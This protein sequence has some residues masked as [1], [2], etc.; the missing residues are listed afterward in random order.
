MR[1][2]ERPEGEGIIYGLF[3]EVGKVRIP[4]VFVDRGLVP[5]VESDRKGESWRYECKPPRHRNP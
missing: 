3:G 5:E 2:A 4:G 1:I